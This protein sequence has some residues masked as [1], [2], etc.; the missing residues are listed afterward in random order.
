MSPK[1][2]VNQMNDFI[3]IEKYGSLVQSSETDSGDVSIL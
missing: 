2:V 1:A 3:K